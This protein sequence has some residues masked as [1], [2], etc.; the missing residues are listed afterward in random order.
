[1]THAGIVALQE[2]WKCYILCR[3][4]VPDSFPMDSNSLLT[5]QVKSQRSIKTRMVR[6]E[7]GHSR[8]K[9]LLG[10]DTSWGTLDQSFSALHK[11]VN[12][13]NKCNEKVLCSEDVYVDMPGKD[14][15][16]ASM[17]SSIFWE[18]FLFSEEIKVPFCSIRD[19]QTLCTSVHLPDAMQPEG[20]SSHILEVIQGP[21]MLVWHLI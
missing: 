7:F 13:Q 4:P 10:L 5:L 11:R 16:R 17:T 6:S 14:S 9:S 12:V 18:G 1:M 15:G 8:F 19:I 3:Y 2:G 21:P 20:T